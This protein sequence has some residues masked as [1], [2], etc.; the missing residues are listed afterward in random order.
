M[1]SRTLDRRRRLGFTLIELLVTV[2]I[3][4]I[5]AAIALP[6]FGRIREKA[7]DSQIRADARSVAD[8]QELHF[9][10]TGTY[11]TAVGDLMFAPSDGSVISMAAGNSGSLATSFSATVTHPG[12]T[13][14]T[15]CV[16]ASDGVPNLTCS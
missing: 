12:M 16:W 11:T 5:L 4:G 8:A 2:S 7:F 15:G 10:D 14:G 6:R 1:R 9:Y 3:I 13:Y